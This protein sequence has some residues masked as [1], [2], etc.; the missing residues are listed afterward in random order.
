MT[1]I[2]IILIIC[3]LNLVSVNQV[4][5]GTIDIKS[6]VTVPFKGSLFSSD[7]TQEERNNALEQGKIVAWK[8]YTAG[9]SGSNKD[10]YRKL[11]DVFLKQISDYI[12]E[13]K[14]LD[15]VIDKS[16]K[17]LTIVLRASI[18]EEAVASALRGSSAAAQQGTGQGSLFAFV[19]VSRELETLKEFQDKKVDIAMQETVSSSETKIIAAGQNV[20]ESLDESSIKKNTTGG[21]VEKKADKMQYKVA[22]SQDINTAM[23]NVLSTAGFEIIEYDDVVTTCRGAER[24]KIMEEYAESDDIS[25]VARK[26]AIEGARECEVKLFA[27]GTLDVGLSDIDP[28]S[29]LKRVYVSARAQVWSLD[30]KLPKKVASVGPVQYSGLGPDAK[31]A[32]RNALNLAS[33]EAAKE[34]VAILNSKG[35]H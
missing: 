22:S 27:T 5:A 2:T 17:E 16:K 20:S 13:V 15:E 14:V 19:F 7:P 30:A 33:S 11:Q 8:K 28:V 12:V 18:D 34:I 32:S 23:S 4:L 26:Q 9:F 29:K 24:A 10:M 21:S 1:K 35:I 31:V 25:G 3:I 6:T